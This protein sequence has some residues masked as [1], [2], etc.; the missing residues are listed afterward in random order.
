[1]KFVSF[2]LFVALTISQCPDKDQYCAHCIGS[3]CQFCWDSF[4]SNG[5]CVKS[6]N[7]R[8]NCQSYSSNGVCLS[9][10]DNYYLDS[11]GLCQQITDNNCSAFVFGVGCISCKNGIKIVEGVCTQGTNCSTLNC[12]NCNQQ[13]LCTKCKSNFAISSNNQC[14]QIAS[15]TSNCASYGLNNAC[16]LCQRGYY[17]K[18][19]ECV[20]FGLFNYSE[21]LLISIIGTFLS[22]L[23]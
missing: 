23:V 13:D 11:T 18:N 22:L 6:T 19:G 17:D 16:L 20:A 7:L 3:V 2:A 15:G 10:E 8:N 21:I 12:E 5:I 4:L 9:C 1:M 14:T